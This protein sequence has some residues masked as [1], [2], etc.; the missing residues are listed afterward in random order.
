M[1]EIQ[2]SGRVFPSSGSSSMLKAAQGN[3]HT[4]LLCTVDPY[5]T[6]ILL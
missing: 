4:V 6:G 1:V 3:V 5:T 2:M